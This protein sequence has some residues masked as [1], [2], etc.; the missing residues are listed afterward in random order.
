MPRSER[1]GHCRVIGLLCAARADAFTFGPHRI[2]GAV[3]VRVSATR[4]EDVAS[5]RHSFRGSC[6]S[7]SGGECV[8]LGDDDCRIEMDQREFNQPEHLL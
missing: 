5:G 8:L 4:K 1:E 6:W 3:G 2:A 7:G